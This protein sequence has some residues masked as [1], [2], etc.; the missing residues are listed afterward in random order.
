MPDESD[1]KRHHDALP[2]EW[3]D[4]PTQELFKRLVVEAEKGDK[5]GVDAAEE[6]LQFAITDLQQVETPA[7][8]WLRAK[9]TQIA[10]GVEPHRALCL[11]LK[12]KGGRPAKYEPEKIMAIDILLRDHAKLDAKAAA[13]EIED[14][15]ELDSR[16]LREL[17]KQYD[18]RFSENQE[19]L[20]AG[21]SRRQLI[22]TAGE[23]LVAIDDLLD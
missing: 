20:L 4:K 19:L 17:R 9:L 10:G 14:R 6:I 13:E 1:D 16:T 5:E 8:A 21:L 11:E 2:T 15:Y 7:L 12:N 23:L 18:G 3:R 22:A